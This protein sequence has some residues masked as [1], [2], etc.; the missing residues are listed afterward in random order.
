[1][2]HFRLLGGISLAGPDGPVPGRS[3]QPRQ[4]AVL[5]RLAVAPGGAL[6][7]DK[8]V[9]CFW[10]EESQSTA[11]HRLRDVVYLLRKELGEETIVST[12]DRLRIDPS[13]LRT[14]VTEFRQALEEGEL[15]RA[16]QLYTGPFLD[17]FY[18][19]DSPG[20]EKWV[21]SER[22]RLAR[23][24][25]QTLE[26]LAEE[27]GES[28]DPE[29]AAACWEKRCAQ[30]PLDSRIALRLMEAYA[31]SGSPAKALRHGRAHERLLRDELGIE[32]G[33]ELRAFLE[34]LRN[35]NWKPSTEAEG[36]KPRGV[37]ERRKGRKER[38]P[39]RA[40]PTSPPPVAEAG[41]P[42]PWPPAPPGSDAPKRGGR[43][44]FV[45]LGSFLL[46]ALVLVIAWVGRAGSGDTRSPEP[47]RA[48]ASDHSVAVFPFENLGPEA[49]ER[50]FVR[51]VRDAILSSLASLEDLVVLSPGSDPVSGQ[52]AGF[53]NRIARELE[54]T[55][56]LVGSVQRTGER[57]RITARLV[58]TD[59]ERQIWAEQFD[60]EYTAE[61][62]F[63]IQ[64]R[65]ARAVA[66]ALEARL[67]P[68]E[69]WRLDRRPTDDITAYDYYLKG[70]ER[71]EL[72][73]REPIAEPET[74]EQSIGLFRR[75][76]DLDPD[77]AP[78]HAGLADA[79]GTL[80]A[81]TGNPSW[82]DS[83][84]AAATQ[85]V[86]LDPE[87]PEAHLALAEFHWRHRHHRHHDRAFLRSVR[88]ALE[89]R[90]NDSRATF[91]VGLWWRLRTQGP[92]RLDQAV[93]WMERAARLNPTDFRPHR[94]TAVMYRNLGDLAVAEAASR[95]A[96]KLMPDDIRTYRDLVE[97]A[98]ARGDRRKAFEFYRTA[99]PLASSSP[100]DLLSLGGMEV[101]LGL[102][103]S[104]SVHL[105]R[106][107]EEYFRTTWTQE[108]IQF[109][110]AL[111]ETGQRHRAR[112]ILGHRE[113]RERRGLAADRAKGWPAFNLAQVLAIRGETDAAVNHVAEAID[114]GWLPYIP[115]VPEL[116]GPVRKLW[117]HP[118]F[119]SLMANFR[120]KVDR[121]RARVELEGCEAIR[122]I[123]DPTSSPD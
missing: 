40:S 101:A 122:A 27:A 110:Y 102:L 114:R 123:P 100:A 25:G 56:L 95:R 74:V 33:P 86:E 76:L 8:L 104:A 38:S 108:E 50:Y 59:S 18:L 58:R 15:R 4:L 34:R 62:L 21:D 19:P 26:T 16:V 89:L 79:Y 80:P 1:M 118:G 49:G 12:G 94:E 60:R 35:G 10:P 71:L 47:L 14:D 43:P 51:G 107:P 73:P 87:L 6:S 36:G 109:A 41:R 97:T 3:T 112:E 2:F 44:K 53:P 116:D 117:G 115:I 90:P 75:A 96:L 24:Y 46:A 5:T 121:I 120:S 113:N 98:L 32:P 88:R 91:L 31:K 23:R 81:I 42:V 7:R 72:D 52:E 55:H 17:G 61:A 99:R 82:T 11:R 67:S 65:I 29:G 103:D 92:R 20:F 85:A 84:L 77:F 37:E 48:S 119:D 30:D 54:A 83:M 39:G 106:I 28:G 13:L 9:G 93:C 45:V 69:D 111:W 70:R 64:K 57:L 78:A 68:D 105:A 66:G 22:R 63:D